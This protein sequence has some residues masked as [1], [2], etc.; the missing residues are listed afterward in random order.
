M[1]TLEI[2]E[3]WIMGSVLVGQPDSISPGALRRA[4]NVRIDR[5]LRSICSRPG[6]TRLTSSAIASGAIVWLSKLFGV[7]TDYSYA[8]VGTVLYR[9]TDAWAS[10]TN[11]V[12][13][14]SQVLSSADYIDGGGTIHKYLVNNSIARKDTGTLLT[15][16]GIAAPTSAPTVT[17]GTRH[18]RSIDIMDASN[19]AATSA[20]APSND[21]TIYQVGSMSLLTGVAADTT[22]SVARGFASTLNLQDLPGEREPTVFVGSGLNNLT[23]SGTFSSTAASIVYEVE[24][25]TVGATD[26]FRY[27]ENGGDWSGN[28]SANVGITTSGLTISFASAGGHTLN[29]RWFILA[30]SPDSTVRDDDWIRLWIRVDRPERLIYMQIDFDLDTT[31]VTDAF[32]RNFFSVRLSALT[33]LSQGRD[34][35]TELKVRKSEFTRY[36]EDTTL[37]W[38]TVRAARISFQTNSEGAIVIYLDDLQLQGGFGIEG[39]YEHTALY[40]NSTTRGKG[41]PPLDTNNVVQYSAPL[42]AARHPLILNLA[43]QIEGGL[44]HPGDTQIDR[45]WVYRKGGALTSVLRSLDVPD[46]TRYAIDTTAD[47]DLIA[48]TLVLE[49]DNNVP[50]TGTT[51]VLFG[52]DAAGHFFMLVNEHRLYFSKAFETNENRVENWPPLNFA[53]IGDGSQ[54][55]M[56]GITQDVNVLV[57]TDAQTYFVQGQGADTFIPVAVPGSRGIVGR[58]AVCAGAGR[59]FF[60]S[61]DGIYEQ[62]S[63]QQRKITGAIDPFFNGETIDGQTPIN[64]SAS[65]LAEIRLLYHSDPYGSFL[66]M[67]YPASGSSTPN[68]QL[69]IKPNAQTGE[70]TDCFFDTRAGLSLTS[71]FIDHEDRQLLAGGSDGHV[72]VLED[73]TVSS[74]AGTA[75][76][77]QARTKSTDEGNPFHNKTYSEISV[78]GNTNSQNVSIAAHYDDAVSSESLSTAFNTSAATSQSAYRTAN[79][80]TKRKN[81]A[82]DVSGSTTSQVTI[83]RF[84]VHAMLL[85]EPR[86]FFDTDEI[87]YLTPHELKKIL[88]DIDTSGSLT[89]TTY[90]NGVSTNIQTVA[91]TSGRQRVDKELPIGVISKNFRITLA[92][93]ATAELYGAT[94]FL[95]QE[96]EELYL[97]DSDEFIFPDVT[98][99]RRLRCDISAPANVTVRLYLDGAL[100][101]T[102]PLFATSGRQR[103]NHLL[104]AGLKARNFRV[105]MQSASLFQL[106][107]LVGDFKSIGNVHGYSQVTLLQRELQM[108]TREIFQAA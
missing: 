93:S 3:N 80:T 82:L 54:K 7:S 61:Q 62:I 87:T 60:V 48:T 68:A 79:E 101:D 5:I 37:G 17:L 70:L 65:A 104:P 107:G 33:R 98:F 102:R 14:G 96:P 78:E 44:S 36:G 49:S 58:F 53:L 72:Y 4:V 55:A 40:R 25:N 35:W 69:V 24:I 50:P 42:I 38:N 12:T 81:I 56:A 85:P 15:M 91:A 23:V 94:T 18:N 52:P 105:E 10:A 46:N 57:W 13:S 20:T 27:R 1:F 39:T 83:T 76:A 29:D 21:T 67:L 11:I 34:Q 88:L 100:K 9:L 90:L 63:L 41:N 32:R 108:V 73:R 2:L 26:T 51:R 86:R 8:Q 71:L 95:R 45:I 84:G 28:I 16:M 103:V 47:S 43:N 22:G 92:G 6:S 77:W 31:V 99:C 66:E 74:D 59:I 89:L 30:H 106:W 64:T 97:F 19:W 75:I